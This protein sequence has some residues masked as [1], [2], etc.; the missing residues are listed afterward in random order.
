MSLRDLKKN[1][2]S[3]RE[4]LI[5]EVDKL[6]SSGQKKEQQVDERIW[7]PQV[8]KPGNGFAVIRFLPA[9]DGE[10]IPWAQTFSH[11]FKSNP[12][13]WFI[14]N[15][16]TTLEGKCPVCEAN[17][18][19]W[20]SGIE[21][22]KEVVRLRKRRLTYIA[23]ILVIQDSA[24]PENEGKVFLFRFGKKIFERINESMFPQFADESAVNPFDFWEGSNFKLKIRKVDG[25]TNYDKSEFVSPAPL[26]DNDE[27]IEEIWKKEYPLKEFT[28]PKLFKSHDE[29]KA[30][31]DK[32]LSVVDPDTADE[33]A[34]AA[35]VAP[36]ARAPRTPAPAAPKAAAPKKVESIP[37]EEDE[38]PDFAAPVAKPVAKPVVKP[39]VAAVD[40]DDDEEVMSY[41]SKL[42]E[43]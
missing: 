7:Y 16:P 21:K 18:V 14:E 41:L 6:K 28:D 29:L 30:K 31:L 42:A 24:E 11:S 39:V 20:N 38:I 17:S 36:V 12:N 10:D 19:L 25:Y 23:N 34:E 9:V 5:A 40:D 27:A 15:C 22:N 26:F 43:E 13:K 1:R 3:I 33:Q 37:F 35:P 8:D 32:F 2:N 4:K